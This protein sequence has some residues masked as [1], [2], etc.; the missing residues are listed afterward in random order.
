MYKSSLLI[1]ACAAVGVLVHAQTAAH[2]DVFDKIRAEGLERSQ[3]SEVFDTL[4]VDIGPRLTGSP[5]HKRAADFARERLAA[6]GL[7][8]A[9][10]EA[11][12]FARSW[13]LEKLTLEMIGPRYMP[14]IGYAEGWSPSTDGEIVATPLVIAGKT[15]GQVEAMRDQLKGAIVMSQSILTNFV[16]RDRADPSAPD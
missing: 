10:L 2:R 13:T 8:D 14:L 3:V 9:R 11:W 5:A 7:S 4:T 6:D 1:S 16:R 12:P 15:A